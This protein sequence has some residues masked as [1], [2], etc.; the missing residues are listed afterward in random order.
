MWISSSSGGSSSSSYRV[1]P[2]FV[3]AYRPP[4]TQLRIER[5]PIADGSLRSD[6]R[7]DLPAPPYLTDTAMGG[8]GP[9]RYPGQL[10]SVVG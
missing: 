3:M 7:R 6:L 10:P 8:A 1:A 4:G 9:R 2:D 5:V